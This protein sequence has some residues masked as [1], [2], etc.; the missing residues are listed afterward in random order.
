MTS[1]LRA[2]RKLATG[3]RLTIR[4]PLGTI[5]GHRNVDEIRELL[6]ASDGATRPVDRFKVHDWRDLVATVNREGPAGWLT[7]V[8][9]LEKSDPNNERWP[10][11]KTHD[12]ASLA[13]ICQWGQAPGQAAIVGRHS[14]PGSG[15]AR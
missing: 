13:M 6:L 11:A 8:R 5:T 4:P 15:H 1:A 14:D 3:S 7:V 2:I 12:D 10:R 9:G